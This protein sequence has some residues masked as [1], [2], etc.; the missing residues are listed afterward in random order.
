MLKVQAQMYEFKSKSDVNKF[1]LGRNFAALSDASMLI[2]P[3]NENNDAATNALEHY[4][5]MLS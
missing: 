3:L 1:W 4:K 5:A 2:R